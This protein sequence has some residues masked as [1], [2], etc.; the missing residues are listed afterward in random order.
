MG[1]AEASSA[2][3]SSDSRHRGADSGTPAGSSARSGAAARARASMCHVQRDMTQEGCGSS[4]LR[5]REL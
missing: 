4:R 3:P 1:S 2:D 5:R